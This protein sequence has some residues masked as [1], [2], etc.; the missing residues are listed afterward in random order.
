MCLDKLYILL[1]LLAIIAVN[2]L[3][4]INIVSIVDQQSIVN[5][6]IKLLS[7]IRFSSDPSTL[8]F[9]ILVFPSPTFTAVN[10]EA[11]L[12][13][14]NSSV[15]K[16]IVVPWQSPPFLSNKLR[17]EKFETELIFSRFYLPHIF[18]SFDRFIYLDNDIV[19]NSD[20]RPL[21]DFPL[22]AYSHYEEE[23]FNE[24][25]ATSTAMHTQQSRAKKHMVPA[26][27]VGDATVGFVFERHHF[28]RYVCDEIPI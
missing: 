5:C 13:C 17:N 8:T 12:P 11:M 20:L 10:V 22:K 19:V 24:P 7:I 16:F 14:L 6:F 25:V 21:F 27:I 28:H 4:S 1:F 2:G 9:G 23:R 26:R 18:P 3:K 15:S